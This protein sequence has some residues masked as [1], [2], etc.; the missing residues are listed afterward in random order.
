MVILNLHTASDGLHPH[1]DRVFTERP[2]R[3][4]VG[5]DARGRYLLV[6]VPRVAVFLRW[7]LLASEVVYV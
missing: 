3:V 4:E 1:A 7:P 2:S 5:R 6:S